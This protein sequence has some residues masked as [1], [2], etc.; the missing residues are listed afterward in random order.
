MRLIT[1]SSKRQDTPQSLDS[2]DAGGEESVTGEI[3]EISSKEATPELLPSISLC[4]EW[5]LNGKQL[6]N[7]K[8]RVI[9]MEHTYNNF[10]G[11]L[12]ALCQPKLRQSQKHWYDDD[13]NIDFEWAWCS[14]KQLQA[15]KPII[16]YCELDGDDDFRAIQYEVQTS[17][18]PADMVLKVLAHI[19]ADI[20]DEANDSA[21]PSTQQTHALVSQ[22]TN[23]WSQ[24]LTIRLL[25]LKKRKLW[26]HLA[27][28]IIPSSIGSYRTI[29]VA[30]IIQG[31]S[32]TNQKTL[33]V[34]T[35]FKLMEKVFETGPHQSVTMEQ[36]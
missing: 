6:P 25:G 20:S 10:L 24:T 19:T 2:D 27:M 21:L 3:E 8:K 11:E 13:V 33:A 34:Q 31:S 7:S 29:Y 4:L 12:Y 30:P 18:N 35:M 5:K 36:H 23:I 22:V 28:I 26:L 15:K 32:V 1:A 16:T 9:T 17:K 14:Q